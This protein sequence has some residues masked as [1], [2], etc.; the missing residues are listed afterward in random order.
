[1]SKKTLWDYP[2][3]FGFGAYDNRFYFNIWGYGLGRKHHGDDRSTPI[4]VDIPVGTKIIGTTGNTGLG[5]G[6]HNHWEK[7]VIKV[8]TLA[9]G[10]RHYK[11]PEDS[12]RGLHGRVVYAGWLG[13]A[14]NCVIIKKTTTP[15]DRKRI[16]YRSLHMDTINVKRGDWV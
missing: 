6:P 9:L 5:T 12:G 1:M 2:V 11:K 15:Q 13:T 7:F 16:F 10:F 4:G 8:G 14:G 3:T